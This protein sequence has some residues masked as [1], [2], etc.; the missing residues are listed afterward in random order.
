MTAT[1]RDIALCAAA[2]QL[3]EQVE[4]ER[5]RLA[6]L[7]PGGGPLL[8]AEVGLPAGQPGRPRGEGF[9][10]T[11][12]VSP[13]HVPPSPTYAHP[14]V[15]GLDYPERVTPDARLYRSVLGVK[16]ALVAPAP[17]PTQAAEATPAEGKPRRWSLWPRRKPKAEPK[18]SGPWMAVR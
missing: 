16:V 18:T 13:P 4:Q 10:G 12:L 14:A 8:N 5:R 17:R 9:G 1:D 11:G 6:S 2:Q 15:A 7:H 3:G